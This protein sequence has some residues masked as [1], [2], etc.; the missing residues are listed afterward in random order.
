MKSLNEF[1]GKATE[2]KEK[3]SGSLAFRTESFAFPQKNA[4]CLNVL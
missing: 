4:C 1:Q 3:L 2:I